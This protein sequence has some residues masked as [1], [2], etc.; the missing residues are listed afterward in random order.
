MLMNFINHFSGSL[1][2]MSVFRSGKRIT[3]REIA[4][5]DLLAILGLEELHRRAPFLLA[6]SFRQR[7]EI[8]SCLYEI[9][10]YWY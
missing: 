4:S 6:D 3:H 7:P 5:G 2:D 1:V 9:V 8:P 10:S